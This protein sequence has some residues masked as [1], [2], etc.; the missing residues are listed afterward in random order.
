[1]SELGDSSKKS[2]ICLPN[3]DIFSATGA[4][5]PVKSTFRERFD[6]LHVNLAYVCVRMR[7]FMWQHAGACE[8]LAFQQGLVEYLT[9]TML[10]LLLHAGYN[11]TVVNSE[12]ICCQ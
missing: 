9:Y 12:L 10:W 6:E 7:K 11:W 5:S 1:M 8:L 3:D 4:S 2:G